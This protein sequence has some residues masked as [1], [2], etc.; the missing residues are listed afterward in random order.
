L[1]KTEAQT[2]NQMTAWNLR[3]SMCVK[4]ISDTIYVYCNRFTGDSPTKTSLN[5]WKL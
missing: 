1:Q 4:I 2:A 5:E 3:R